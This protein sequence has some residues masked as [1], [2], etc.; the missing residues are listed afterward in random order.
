MFVILLWKTIKMTLKQRR[1]LKNLGKAGSIKEAAIMSGYAVNNAGK[2]QADIIKG[3]AVQEEL[4][5]R[6]AKALK[7]YDES[8]DAEKVITSPAEPD[9]IFPD[10]RIRL[11]AVKTH[12]QVRGW[13][14]DESTRIEGDVTININVS[15]IQPQPE[16]SPGTDNL[17]RPTEIQDTELA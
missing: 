9:R 10:H 17:E 1:L 5:K 13:L 12:F 14:K 3:L 11:D 8:F 2:N 6:D 15:D 4:A 7:R 16:L